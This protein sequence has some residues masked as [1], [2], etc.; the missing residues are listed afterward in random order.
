MMHRA[1]ELNREI[2]SQPAFKPFMKDELEPGFHIK[3]KAD[4]H[5]YILEHLAGDYHPVGTC[6]IG[7]STDPNAVVDSELRVHGVNNPRIAD[8]SVMP[9]ITNANTNATSIMIGE[10]AAD[11][12][13]NEGKLEHEK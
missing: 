2:M 12:I 10:R 6:K 4:I 7:A 8:A 9:V 13:L 5:Q 1:F 11:L 3:S